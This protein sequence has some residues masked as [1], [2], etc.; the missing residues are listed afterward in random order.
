MVY[1]SSVHNCQAHWVTA[2]CVEIAIRS[3]STFR[4]SKICI[5]V[6]WKGAEVRWCDLE[7]LSIVSHTQ[8]LRP[9]AHMSALHP[10]RAYHLLRL[11]FQNTQ[12]QA[13]N[14][15]KKEGDP[16]FSTE[17]DAFPWNHFWGKHGLNTHSAHGSYCFFLCR[18]CDSNILLQSNQTDQL[19][20]FNYF[21]ASWSEGQHRSR[22]CKYNEQE[23]D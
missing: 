17:N 9:L 15:W 14:C 1:I 18:L 5:K 16:W 22:H 3:T 20:I 8:S 2:Q 11:T 10:R 21:L 19:L 4:A 23:A 12:L 6:Y 7:S 13:S